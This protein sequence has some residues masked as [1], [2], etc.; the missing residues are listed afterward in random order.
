MREIVRR[1]ANQEKERKVYMRSVFS[2]IKKGILYLKANGL[3]GTYVKV[4][5]YLKYTRMNS[6]IENKDYKKWMQNCERID[7]AQIQKEMSQFAYKPLFSICI[8]VYNVEEK[9]LEKCI[10][11]V[12]NQYYE[13]WQLCLADD[14]STDIRVRE[15]LKRYQQKDSRIQVIYRKENGHISRATNSALQIA[16]GEFIVLMDNDDEISRDALFEVVKLL[17]QHRDADVIYSDS[18]KITESEERVDPYFKP[19]YC[20]DTL[21]SYNYISHLGIYRKTLIDQVGGFRIGVEG[22]QDYD[23]LLRVTELTDRVYHIPKILYH[24][25][26]IEGSTASGVGQKN[27]AYL[28]GKKVLEDAVRRRGYHARVQLLEKILCYNMKF[29]PVEEHFYSIIIWFNGN[30]KTLNRCLKSIYKKTLENNFEIIVVSNKKIF[31]KE[32]QNFSKYKNVS[33]VICD[34]KLNYSELNNQAVKKAKGDL[35]LFID[36]NIEILSKNW[37]QFMAGEAERKEIGVIGV[38][39]LDIKNKVYHAGI[40][41][42][43]SGVAGYIGCGKDKDDNGY[44]SCLSVRRNYMAVCGKCFMVRKKIFMEIKGFDK[45][46]NE[47]YQDIDLCVRINEKGY[48]NIFLPDVLMKYTDYKKKDFMKSNVRKKDICRM[49][50]KWGKKIIFDPY[51]SQNF[52]LNSSELRIKTHL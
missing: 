48:Q 4:R 16:K 51:Y 33:A 44:M 45:L 34:S 41:M 32:K 27:Y 31:Q 10:S 37:L 29:Y 12:E 18:D 28:A 8:P 38:K 26:I 23:L 42:G 22:S 6:L 21:L 7:I 17:Q 3:P 39:I 15:V 2:V 47:K 43:L 30:L 11:S 50:M 49:Q 25:R 40:A 9:W 24:W 35:L 36:D 1:T 5:H 14:C 13:N 46:L 52:E 20:P 19:D